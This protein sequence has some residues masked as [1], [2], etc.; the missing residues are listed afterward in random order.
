MAEELTPP[1]KRGT[2]NYLDIMMA[3]VNF[4]I[5][6]FPLSIIR[7]NIIITIL[8]I[9]ISS[10]VIISAIY[11]FSIK[12]PFYSMYCYVLLFCGFLFIY[13]LIAINLIYG[14]LFFLEGFYLWINSKL[15]REPSHISRLAQYRTDG[16]AGS[17]GLNIRR[18][19]MTNVELE[20]EKKRIQERERLAIKYNRKQILI[21]CLI[22]GLSLFVIF[23]VFIQSYV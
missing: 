17:M 11:I 7:N 19:G 8:G 2:S 6:I 18:R 10:V 14:G 3:F 23:I 21:R 15:R 12:N 13:P 22:L 9:V 16:I 4:L 5:I 1:F 20:L